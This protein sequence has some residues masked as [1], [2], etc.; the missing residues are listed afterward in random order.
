MAPLSA[1]AETRKSGF[2]RFLAEPLVGESQG[3]AK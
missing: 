3:G 1:T 2:G